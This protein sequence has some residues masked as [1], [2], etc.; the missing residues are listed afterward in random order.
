[1]IFKTQI[2]EIYQ[3]GG[4]VFVEIGPRQ[5]LGNLVKDILDGKPHSVVSVNPS[6]DKSSDRQLRE[7]VVTLQVI[8]LPIKD[9]DPFQQDW[10]LN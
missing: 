6:R 4:R 3:N 10:E 7:A 2:E 8:G 9:I 1:V 5:V